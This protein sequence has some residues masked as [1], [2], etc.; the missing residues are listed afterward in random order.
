MST[1]RTSDSSRPS[2]SH[3]GDL[4]EELASM[5]SRDREMYLKDNLAT[6]LVDC[7]VL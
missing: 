6:S 7:P 5:S 2:N 4:V 3:T 1:P